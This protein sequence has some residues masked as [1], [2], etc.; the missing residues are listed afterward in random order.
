M[1]ARRN[2]ST[3]WMARLAAVLFLVQAALLGFSMGATAGVLPHDQFGNVLC[4]SDAASQDHHA[5]EEKNH[6]AGLLACCTLGCGMFGGH[7]APLPT[8]VSLLIRQP[9]ALATPFV[10]YQDVGSG[11]V[12]TP[13]RTR[14]PPI[15]V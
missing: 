4:S 12:E 10:L 14:G 11:A 15:L 1:K 7:M 8:L 9:V 2:G 5:P 6:H 13:R 3:E